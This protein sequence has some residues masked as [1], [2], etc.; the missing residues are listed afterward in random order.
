MFLYVK[1]EV[2]DPCLMLI[3]G[4]GG[5]GAGAFVAHEAVRD[6]DIAL[7]DCL[8]HGSGAKVSSVVIII[9]CI[10]IYL[11]SFLAATLGKI[12]EYAGCRTRCGDGR[13]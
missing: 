10:Y 12:S 1:E 6:D 7:V 5:A 11:I 8:E 2:L 9:V 13:G 4:T 3:L